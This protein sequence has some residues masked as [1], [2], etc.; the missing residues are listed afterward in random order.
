MAFDGFVLVILSLSCILGDSSSFHL[1]VGTHLGFVFLLYILFLLLGQL[2][3]LFFLRNLFIE[4]V[5][6]FS[7]DHVVKHNGI[8]LHC[9]PSSPCFSL[10]AGN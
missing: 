8:C 6:I 5:N 9:D 10:N 1:F 4:V 2:W 7:V 3:H